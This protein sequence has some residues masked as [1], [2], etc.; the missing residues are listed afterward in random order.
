MLQVIKEQS[1]QHHSSNSGGYQFIN[2]RILY[3]RILLCIF[4]NSQYLMDIVENY[5]L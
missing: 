3:L 1:D 4:H 2:Q 5:L